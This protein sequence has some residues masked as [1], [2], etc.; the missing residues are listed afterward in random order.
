MQRE[1]VCPDFLQSLTKFS[2]SVI[3]EE[4]LLQT[5]QYYMHSIITNFQSLK[6]KN[7]KNNLEKNVILLY[8]Y[9][10]V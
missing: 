9:L 5:E 6:S 4:V 1:T 8:A 10:K 2:G 3:K 7:F